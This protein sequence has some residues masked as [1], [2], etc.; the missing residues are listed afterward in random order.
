MSYRAINAKSF[1][2][3]LRIENVLSTDIARDYLHGTY[4][5]APRGGEGYPY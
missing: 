2:N 5:R 3:G 1:E 4:I